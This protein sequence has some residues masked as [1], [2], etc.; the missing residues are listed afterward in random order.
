MGSQ[1]QG[2]A[3]SSPA[4]PTRNNKE[5][6]TQ[7]ARLKA[8][9]PISEEPRSSGQRGGAAVPTRSMPVRHHTVE[10]DD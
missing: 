1:G 6:A 2:K 10:A 7:A 9:P 4:E 8:C 3:D 5:Q